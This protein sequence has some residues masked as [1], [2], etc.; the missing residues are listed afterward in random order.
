M[1]QDGIS[2]GEALNIASR[3]TYLL[4]DG[5]ISTGELPVCY[6]CMEPLPAESA[7]GI[8]RRSG[9]WAEVTGTGGDPSERRVVAWLSP[10]ANAPIAGT[11]RLH[12]FRQ[13]VLRRYPD[14]VFLTYAHRGMPPPS[15][16]QPLGG[17]SSMY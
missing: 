2:D 3:D 8:E 9:I 14:A 11:R 12:E 17:S 1:E 15:D 7:G 10:R 4:R 6:D 5:R 16:E 13:A